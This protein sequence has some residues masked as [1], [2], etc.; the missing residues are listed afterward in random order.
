MRRPIAFSILIATTLAITISIAASTPGSGST[1]TLIQQSFV[2]AYSR[3][4]FASLTSAAANNVAPLVSNALQQLFTSKADGTNTYALIMPDQTAST[5]QT[6]Q[7]YEDIYKLYSAVGASTA[8]VPTMD[9]TAC[10][11]LSFGVCDYQI[12]TGNYAFFAYSTPSLNVTIKDPYFTIWN[13]AG[14]VSG[15]FGPP[16]AGTAT[17]TSAISS[18]VGTQQNFASGAIFSWPNSSSTP[19]VYGLSGAFY[20]LYINSNGPTTLGFPTSVAAVV[21]TMTGLVQQTFEGG[22]IQQLPGSDPVVVYPLGQINISNASQ[23]LSLPAGASATLTALTLDSQQDIVTGRALTWSS[24]NGAVATVVGNGYTATVTGVS[25]GAANIYVTGEGKTS[26]ALVVTV[27]SGCCS[28]GQGAPSQTISGSF[29]TAALRNSLPAGTVA[30]GTVVRTGAGYTQT[31]EA[32]GTTYVISEADGAS[33]A[34]V[35][36]GTFYAAYLAAGGFAGPLGYPVTDLLAGNAQKFASGAA[37]AGIPPQV[38][39][40]QIAGKWFANQAVAGLPSSAAASFSA[41]T[42]TSGLSQAFASG[43]IYA[44]TSEGSLQGQAFLLTGAILARYTALLGPSGALGAPTSDVASAGGVLTETFEG[45]SISLSPGAAA[46]VEHYNPR[47]PALSA[48][49]ATVAPGGRVHITA[50]GFAPGATL[51]FALTGQGNFSVP[52]SPGAFAWDVVV[53]ASAKPA[54]VT[55]SA[56][57]PGSKDTATGGYSIVAPAALLPTLTVT[58]GDLQTGY[59][60][61]QLQLPVVAVLND[62][63][64]NPIPNLPVALSTSPGASATGPAVTDS[65]GRVSVLVRLPAQPGV[66]TGSIAAGGQVVTFS[67]LAS[68][69]SLP[70][71][72]GLAATGQQTTLLASFASALLYY[73]NNGI[74]PASGGAANVAALTSYLTAHG[75]FAVSDT[76]DSIPN[77]WVA[78]QFSSGA[79]SLQAS[80]QNQIRDLVASGNPAIVNLSLTVDGKP[81]GGASVDAIGVS[82]DGSI[83]IYDPNPATAQTSL[84]AYLNGFQASGHVYSA[85]IASVVAIVPAQSVT[86]AAPFT[87]ASPIT[88]G[89]SI[90]GSSGSCSTLDLAGPTAPG[91]VRYQSCDGSA[92]LYEFDLTTATGATLVDLSG[93]PSLQIPATGLRW[94]LFR[95][96]GALT[97]SAAALTIT[98]VTDSAA[99]ATALA[100]NQIFSVF[101][102]G[103]VAKGLTVTLGGKP[104]QTIS[105]S[106]FQINA[107]IPAG[108]AAA[109]STPL[110]VNSAGASATTNVAVGA[111]A[112]GIFTVGSLGAILNQDATLNSPAN[113]AQRGQYVSI[114]CT[115]LGATTAS[116]GLQVAATAVSVVTG[117]QTLKPLYAGAV[118]GFVGLYQVNVILPASLAPGL[119]GTVQLVQG[120]TTSNVVPL[121]LD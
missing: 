18:A 108:T 4:A 46:A 41:Y 87:V 64:G 91:A 24:S 101:G 69:G 95:K 68:A 70:A 37:L 39:P 29:Q 73:Q 100:P 78:A 38:I 81:A 94:S 83:A 82:S 66:V 44:I 21:N 111:T 22:K 19:A 40:A 84:N 12:F 92:S 88:G 77:P 1:T 109:A 71:F 116:G 117:G 120:K 9:T 105:V 16:I 27:G 8:G 14:G 11:A 49:P 47:T 15:S 103:F 23:G 55:I 106:P 42:G 93:G 89:A 60:G 35:I 121:A 62:S 67:A 26:P 7:V 50:S 3:G 75:G 99:F 31:L 33:T 76:G 58:S 28:I 51:N 114:Y 96:N 61:A 113:P 74:L 102:T 107:L 53:P 97:A 48:V 79:L 59:P 118:A 13:T 43:N 20:N 119:A 2:S 52:A 34:Y 10:P 30:S 32:A 86:A 6:W 45:G 90:A 17:V 80:T 112:P 98:G 57:D 56:T 85:T 54:A 25:T 36:S 110:V 104:V 72:S 65:Q 115:G 5:L 63:A